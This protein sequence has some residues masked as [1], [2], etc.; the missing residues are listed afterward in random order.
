MCNYQYL[1][2]ILYIFLNPEYRFSPLE[3]ICISNI[4]VYAEMF[5][6]LRLCI[7]PL[8]EYGYNNIG[9]ILLGIDIDRPKIFDQT[10]KKV[11]IFEKER[12]PEEIIKLENSE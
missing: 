5:I 3:S 4:Y 7:L 8:C 9:T 11:V 12:L 6:L 1:S 10:F 2:L